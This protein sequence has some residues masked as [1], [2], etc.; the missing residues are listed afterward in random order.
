MFLDTVNM[1]G[2]WVG[3]IY[4]CTGHHIIIQ[5]TKENKHNAE[6]Q[7]TDPSTEVRT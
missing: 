7:R 4:K 2:G 1:K 6:L 3:I 5:I